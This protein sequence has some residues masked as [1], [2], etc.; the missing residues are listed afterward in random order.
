MNGEYLF[1]LINPQMHSNVI[2][3]NNKIINRFKIFNL[4]FLFIKSI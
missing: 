1:I 2:K 3:V 4:F